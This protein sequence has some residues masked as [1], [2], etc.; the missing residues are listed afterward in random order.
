[1]SE[2][3]VVEFVGETLLPIPPNSMLDNAPRDMTDLV[4]IGWNADGE[5]YLAL[6]MPDMPEALWMLEVAKKA[7][8][9]PDE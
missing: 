1:M 2:D 5:M 8:L 3:N 4:I 9:D 6:S 7:I